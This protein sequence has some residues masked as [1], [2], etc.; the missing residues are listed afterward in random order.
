MCSIVFCYVMCF[1]A[2]PG[3]PGTRL[4]ADNL[5][6]LRAQVRETYRL[7]VRETYSLTVRETYWLTVRG[8]S[9]GQAGGY[10]MI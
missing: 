4:L 7:T 5:S 6:D 9:G 10:R 2:G 1:A 8:L 3:C